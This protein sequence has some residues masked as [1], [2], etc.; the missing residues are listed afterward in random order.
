VAVPASHA[1]GAPF[2]ERLCA[3]RVPSAAG[4]AVWAAAVPEPRGGRGVFCSHSVQLCGGGAALPRCAPALPRRTCASHALSRR[5]T[6][7]STARP[8]GT[9]QSFITGLPGDAPHGAFDGA[10]FCQ[11][12]RYTRIAC[13]SILRPQRR[14]AQ[15]LPALACRPAH[16]PATLA[17]GTS[18]RWRRT[19]AG[20]ARCPQRCRHDTTA[21]SSKQRAACAS[22]LPPG[23]GGTGGSGEQQSWLVGGLGGHLMQC[24]GVRL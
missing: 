19:T 16:V 11:R 2:G 23:S 14:F 12:C 10:T 21:H 1:L 15:Q 13:L 5:P 18:S 24:S 22:V 6:L 8:A 20:A 9:P 7:T 17:A 4:A 3:G